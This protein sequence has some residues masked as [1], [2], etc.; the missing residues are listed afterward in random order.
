[1]PPTPEIE[2]LS[3]SS[4]QVAQGESLTLS[5]D[6]RKV[7]TFDVLVNNNAVANDVSGDT[8]SLTIDTS[9]LSG[10]IDITVIA[11]NGSRDTRQSVTT[12]VYVPIALN[13]FEVNPNPLIR[14]TVNTVTISWDIAG[15]A[16]VRISGLSD[17]T[18]N[19]IQSSTEY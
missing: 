2:Q 17:F 10:N 6:A 19:L 5:I 4:D 15:A 8:E 3:I 9:T 7:N 14:N 13:T 1:N 16:F 11:R 12:Y 18:N